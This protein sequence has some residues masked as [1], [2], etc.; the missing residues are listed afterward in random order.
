M[1][2][3]IIDT[4]T[5]EKYYVDVSKTGENSIVC[6]VCSGDR[7]KKTDRCLRWNNDKGTGLCHH[8]NAV[9]VSNIL[10]HREIKTYTFPQWKNR[11]ELTDKAVKWFEGRGISQATL[12]KMK[13]GYAKE[14]MPQHN[15]E[16]NTV[17]FPYYQNDILVNIKFRTADKKFKM[18]EGSEL[19]LYNIDAIQ[20]TDSLII[21]EGEMDALTYIECGFP[22]VVSVPNGAGASQLTYLDNYMDYLEHIKVFYIAT[23][24]DEPGL[25]LRNELVRRL[26]VERCK[27][28]TYDGYKDV[29]ELLC[30]KSHFAVKDTIAKSVDSPMDGIIAPNDNR[31]DFFSMWKEGLPS[32]KSVG[33][34]AIDQYIRWE[35]GRLAIWTGFPASGK[36]E[37][38]DFFV[39][40]LN[41]RHGWKA[42]YFSPENY[43]IVIH[44]AKLVEK[45]TGKVF[46]SRHISE[47]DMW[48]AWDYIGENFMFLDPYDDPTLGNIL[49]RAKY[50]VRKKGIKQLIIDPFNTLEHKSMPGENQTDYISRFLDELS[51]FARKYD[52]IINLVAHPTKPTLKKMESP[53]SNVA[54]LYDISGSAHFYNKADYG[55]SIYR[56]FE[57]K[58]S[59]FYPL[60]VRFKNLGEPN[61]DGIIL[62]YNYG[63]GRFSPQN[64]LY[65]NTN[66][67][68]PNFQDDWVKSLSQS[69]EFT[70]IPNEDL[71][72]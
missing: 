29:N 33:I 18:N 25:K 15:K 32:G 47:D 36:S 55:I 63:N 9:F 11:T 70:E 17:C 60:K 43:P 57:N 8:C 62:N 31:D 45:L 66:W 39:V 7:K 21:T 71:P 53:S 52:I 5:K 41:I 22:N 50:C 59:V 4:Q 1:N 6:P 48:E 69:K 16:V 35:T 30:A 42:A 64:D 67:L 51:R 38:L 24:F 72:Y 14:Y 19:I 34:P 40:K 20:T 46:N 54:T 37:M 28:V 44:I 65:D 61:R 26:G 3:F 68:N 10:R 56:D 13:I 27:I 49:D 12:K 58:H 2:I 23:D